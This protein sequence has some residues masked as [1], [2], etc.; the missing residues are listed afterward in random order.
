M[1]QS[2]LR[3]NTM[4]IE[5]E[6]TNKIKNFYWYGSCFALTLLKGGLDIINVNLFI[7][8]HFH[9]CLRV[10]LGRLQDLIVFLLFLV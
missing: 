6:I 1:K 3:Q 9:N 7:I 5:C 2:M 10:C 4:K 8:I